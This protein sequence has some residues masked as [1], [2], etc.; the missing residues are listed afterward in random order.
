MAVLFLWLGQIVVLRAPHADEADVM[1]DDGWTT[2]A[3]VI[4]RLQGRFPRVW[5]L[6][7]P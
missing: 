6:V 3:Q 1:A 4:E 5:L 7:A 2:L